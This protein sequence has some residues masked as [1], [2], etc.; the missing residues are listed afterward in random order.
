MATIKLLTGF[1]IGDPWNAFYGALYGDADA[2]ATSTSISLTTPY[3][4]TLVFTGSFTVVGGAVTAGT[5]TGFEAYA[6]STKVLSGSS[7]S[8][9]GAA[10]YNAIVTFETDT[11]PFFDLFFGVPTRFQGSQLGDDIH[12]GTSDD[13]ILGRKG[14]DALFGWEGND[15]VMGGKGNDL[16]EGGV[17]FNKLWGNEGTDSFGFDLI[18]SELPGFSRI[19]DFTPGEDVIGLSFYDIVVPPG[20]L[21]SSFFHKGT[22][23]ITATQIIIYDKA[24]GNIYFDADGS[25]IG[26]QVNFA[27]VNPGTK[28]SEDDFY[29]QQILV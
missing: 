11:D 18:S 14:D 20:Y 10:L 22:A 6:G 26:T 28:L 24:T 19:K 7:Y 9:D 1:P 13:L 21:G 5:M 16:V 4:Y 2:I 17:G 27:R 15:I 23:A 8:L 25:G 12:G 3:G 29:V